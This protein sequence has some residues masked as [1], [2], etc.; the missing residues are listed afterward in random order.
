MKNRRNYY[1]ILHVQPDAPLALIVASYRTLMHT[2]K[3]HPDLGG[4]HET[5]VMINEAYEILTDTKKRQAYDQTLL[6]KR[7]TA[8][9]SQQNHKQRSS[10]ANQQGNAARSAHKA[11][12]ASPKSEKFDINT[13]P[14]Q[15]KMPRV[16]LGALVSFYFEEQPK[17]KYQGTIIDFSP[18]G[19]QMQ[20]K[21]PV[22]IN[23]NIRVRSQQLTAKGI[24]SYCKPLGRDLW[25]IGILLLETEYSQRQGGFFEANV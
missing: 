8:S 24:I 3:N 18:A 9:V 17:V 4:D 10:S 23:G 11:Q 15:R 6:A 19:L 14:E 1:R 16:K 12:Q 25:R 13:P 7:N 2:L 20:I 22:T 5:A 21:V